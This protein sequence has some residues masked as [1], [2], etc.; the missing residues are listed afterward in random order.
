MSVV[1]E[2][3][4]LDRKDIE[5]LKQQVTAA[6]NKPGERPALLADDI[7][8]V[9]VCMTRHHHH[10]QLDIGTVPP[11]VDILSISQCTPQA[12]SASVKV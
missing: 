8:I 5:R 9:D 1:F 3:P 2:W 12:A 10:H 7:S 4:R 11:E 6:V